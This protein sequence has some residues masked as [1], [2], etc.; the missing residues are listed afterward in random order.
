MRA[1]NQPAFRPSNFGAGITGVYQQSMKA[2]MSEDDGYSY[3]LDASPV[4]KGSDLLDA[5]DTA[6][7]SPTPQLPPVD[8]MGQVGY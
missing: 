6:S 7:I 2:S 5:D 1:V 8:L 4:G 3:E